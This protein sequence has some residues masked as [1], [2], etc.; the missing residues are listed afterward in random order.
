MRAICVD[1]EYIPLQSLA[2]GVESSDKISEVTAFDDETDAIEWAEKHPLDVA[3]LD[4]ELHTMNGLELAEELIKIHPHISI[5]FCTSYEQYAVRALKMHIDAGYLIKPI[6]KEQIHE[7]INHIAK[8]IHDSN[9]FRVKCFGDFEVFVNNKPLNLKRTRT[10]EL[11]AYLIDR[12]GASVSASNLCAVLWEDESIDKKKKDMLYHL[13]A[14]LKS[15]LE[16]QDLND[17][18]VAERNGY[19]VNTDNI[20]CDYYRMLDGDEQ[21][22]RE[23]TGEY[24]SQYSWAEYTNSWLQGEINE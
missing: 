18:F 2:K 17:I 24:M 13:V 4:I 14:D 12:R 1:D 19:S 3:F 20:D 9:R 21:A 22:K 8:K 15:S 10:K 5:V 11:L 6:R 7:E 23:Y 16:E